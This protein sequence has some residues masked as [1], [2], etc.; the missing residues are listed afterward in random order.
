MWLLATPVFLINGVLRSVRRYKFWSM[1]YRP[2]I[3]CQT[4]NAVISLVGMWECRCGYTYVGH[5][6]RQCPVC[7]TLPRMVRCFCCGT[8]AILPQP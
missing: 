2:R 6:L 8:T 1:A 3:R 5:V 4:C 7:E